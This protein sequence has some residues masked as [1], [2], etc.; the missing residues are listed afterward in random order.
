M[1]VDGSGERVFDSVL[2]ADGSYTLRVF[3]MRAAARRNESSQ[4][5]ISIAV[6]GKPLA[7]V[8]AAKDALIPGTSF[9]ARAMVR[10][11]P[12]YTN[13]RECEALVVRRSLDGT[14][15][16]ELRWDKRQKRRILFVKGTPTAADALQPFTFT[17]NARGYVVIFGESER[18]DVPEP[19]VFGG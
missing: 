15:T 1:F 13:L 19:L 9:H 5:T 2:P 10:C 16:V 6:I 12:A 8:P 7:P 11:E 18:F 4:Y 17:R 14:A 3:L